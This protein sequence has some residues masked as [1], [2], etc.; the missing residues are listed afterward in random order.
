[1]SKRGDIIRGAGT[2]L[3]RNTDLGV[4]IGHPQGGNEGDI[5]VQ[6][7]DG[8]PKLYA[9]AGGRWYGI[10]M[11]DSKSDTLRIGDLKN[12]IKISE[13]DINMTGKISIVS[14]GTQNVSIGTGN[15]DKGSDNISIGVNAGAAVTSASTNNLFIGTNAGKECTGAGSSDDNVVIGADAVSSDITPDHVVAIGRNAGK[16]VDQMRHS[17]A[18][19]HHAMIGT[20]SSDASVNPTMSQYNIAIGAGAME[21]CHATVD[22]GG[23]DPRGNIAI[24]QEALKVISGD[25]NINIGVQSGKVITTGSKNTCVGWTA[26]LAIVTGSDSVYLGANADASDTGI[27]NEIAIGKDVTGKGTNTAVIGNSSV[28]DI[29]ASEDSGATVHCT[30]VTVKETTTPSALADHGKIYTKDDN[31]LYFQDGAGTEHEI[32]FA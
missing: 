1:M 7:V 11:A 32:S 13:G 31:K 24:G 4:G 17:I 19:G 14:K 22:A 6:M 25:N 3:K 8:S 9:R 30:S 18:I 26:G 20:N 2:H 23:A 12:Y 27:D 29:Y 10:N 15:Q 21:D 5:R 28:T 16:H